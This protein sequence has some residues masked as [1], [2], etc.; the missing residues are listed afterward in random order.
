MLILLRIFSDQ[1]A[2]RSRRINS[3]QMESR[4]PYRS[5]ARARYW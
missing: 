4:P 5:V 3:L 2:R 1:R